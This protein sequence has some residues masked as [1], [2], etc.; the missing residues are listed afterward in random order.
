MVK[1]LHEKL[2][3]L[4]IEVVTLHAKGDS[5]E[6]LEKYSELEAFHEALTDALIRLIQEKWTNA[7]LGGS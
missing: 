3:I 1:P 4:G 6:A 2:H 5:K 7:N